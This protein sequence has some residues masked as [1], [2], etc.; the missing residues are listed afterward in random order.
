MVTADDDAV[1]GLLAVFG[2]KPTAIDSVYS[3]T[4]LSPFLI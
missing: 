4:N 2:V 1:P 3:T